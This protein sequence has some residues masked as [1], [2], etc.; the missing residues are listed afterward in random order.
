LGVERAREF[1]V[2]G[3]LGAGR[4]RLVRQL[5][6]ENTLVITVGGLLGLGFAAWTL[7]VIRALIPSIVPRAGQLA[8]GP[9]TVVVAGVAGAFA[10][11]VC[12]VVPAVALSRPSRDVSLRESQMSTA[13]STR[14]RL[15]DGLAITELALTLVLLTAS[16]LLFRSFASLTSVDPGFVRDHVAALQVFAW[17]HHPTPDARRRFLQETVDRMRHVGG[18]AAASA[19]SAMPFIESNIA[20]RTTLA[21]EGRPPMADRDA[22]VFLTIATD[23]YFEAMRIPL[24]RG[25]TFS[26]ADRADTD[27]VVVVSES[28]ARRYWGAADPVGSV[29]SVRFEGKMRRARVIGIA[30][31]VRHTGLGAPARAE[32]YLPHAQAPFGSMT[33]VVRTVA[34]PAPL[35]DTLRAQVWAVDPRQT[36]YDVAVVDN[37]VSRSVAPQR[38]GFSLVGLLALGTLVVSAI[39]V[40]GVISFTTSLR[41]R[42]IGVRIA[43]GASAGE[44]RRLVLRHGLIVAACGLAVGAAGSLMFSQLL[45]GL[46]FGVSARDP[47]TLVGSIVALGAIVAVASWLPARRATRVDP[48]VALRQ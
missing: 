6:V 17:D 4:T 24:R 16:G 27:A 1:S 33:Y 43:L 41:T 30:G 19:V 26:P 31:D 34:D 11:I 23:G 48:I 10:V 15:R 42:E 9:A 7:D 45:K 37:L 40:Y 44:V 14:R 32:V 35:L 5:L 29:A 38:L 47:L 22:A 39:G 25:R 20:M 13:G 36:F 8:F 12:G 18:V 46:L 28:A 21:P 3:A 2:R